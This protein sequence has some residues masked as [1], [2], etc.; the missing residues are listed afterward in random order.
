MRASIAVALAAAMTTGC[1]IGRTERSW[2]VMGTYA[3]V[4]A[5]GGSRAA[6]ERAIDAARLAFDGVDA[7]MSNWSE[8][9]ALSRVNREAR[10]GAARVDDAG[11]A[12][13]LAASLDAADATG[14]AFDPTVGPLMTLWGFR[15]RRP[16]VP[17]DD[18]IAAALAHVGRSR[19]AYDRSARTLRFEDPG[20]EIDLGGIA[21]GC[22]LDVAAARIPR[23]AGEAALAVTLD[24]GGGMLAI[25]AKG[26][27]TFLIADPESAERAPVAAV[28]APRDSSVASSSDAENRFES[29]GRLYG[30]IMDARTGRPAVTD[31]LQAT[32]L[33]PSATTTDLL[34]TALFV[35]G[36]R[37]APGILDRYPG[38]E[39]ILIV[40][41][42]GGLAM[43]AS[44]S[45]E[46]R[47]SIEPS[48]R[49]RFTAGSPRF[50]LP[51]ATMRG[52]SPRTGGSP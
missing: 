7:S 26:G 24:L 37:G 32:A 17:A 31:V 40:R 51:P 50:A 49:S 23:A 2:P 5:E 42:P 13:C 29:G 34:S 38:A 9:S 1:A 33:H 25:G 36:S 52:R 19:V 39:A 6:R 16:R 41:E 46:G 14:G 20:M 4:A 48:A 35:A 30:H 28:T 47:L 12:A 22:A 27:S 45:L 10:H 44:A 8:T 11:L 43:I 21:K 18:E 3:R 15:P